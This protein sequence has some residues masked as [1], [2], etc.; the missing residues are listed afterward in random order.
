MTKACFDE[1]MVNM[2]TSRN[3]SQRIFPASPLDSSC[4]PSV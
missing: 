4:G 3:Q 2:K 1:N